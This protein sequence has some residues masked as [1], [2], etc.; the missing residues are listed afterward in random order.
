MSFC[1]MLPLGV[2]FFSFS[3]KFS[4]TREG[5]SLYHDDYLPEVTNPYFSPACWY[6]REVP[7]RL[8]WA[9]CTVSMESVLREASVQ[10]AW[11]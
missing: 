6:F 1:R 4:I 2:H 8:E 5:S 9:H 7:N 3:S 10:S 11:P